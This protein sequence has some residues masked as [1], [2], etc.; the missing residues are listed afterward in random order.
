MSL[1]RSFAMWPLPLVLALTLAPAAQAQIDHR[2]SQSSV[3]NQDLRGTCV[4]FSVAGALE[5]FPGC[6]SDLSEQFMY[7]MVKKKH[8]GVVDTQRG[9]GQFVTMNEGST[10]EQ[11]A[12]WLHIYGAPHETYL[13]Y[14]GQATAVGRGSALREFL[15][16]GQVT[17]KDIERVAEEFGKYR[18]GE[19]YRHLPRAE[20]ANVETIQQLLLS[21]HVAVPVSYTLHLPTWFGLDGYKGNAGGAKVPV[22]A[23]VVYKSPTGAQL[24]HATAKALLPDF[25][26]GVAAG[27]YEWAVPT[28]KTGEFGGHAVLIVGFT[29]DAF[30]VKNSWGTGWGEAGYC[31]VD[32]DYHATF[33]KEALLVRSTGLRTANLDPFKQ[34]EILKGA[35]FRLKVQP[36]LAGGALEWNLSTYTMNPRDPVLERVEYV[37]EF[38]NPQGG[39][40]ALDL[41]RAEPG[42]ALLSK[43]TPASGFGVRVAADLVKQIGNLGMPLRV[44][45]RYLDSNMVAAE[46]LAKSAPERTYPTF[47]AKLDHMLDLAPAK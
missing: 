39:W 3:K 31:F 44:R 37:M 25:R 28:D 21:G 14:G 43:D 8:S 27:T 40:A 10:L 6:P 17:A 1:P 5:T 38:Q 33:A 30:I 24:P 26:Q 20:A 47:A 32:Y 19:D 12:R 42:N 35:E 15:D 16:Q 45:V 11:H 18:V 13:P 41:N 9:M 4:A 2:P 46:V 23:M 22:P 29:K 34:S 7:A 36:I